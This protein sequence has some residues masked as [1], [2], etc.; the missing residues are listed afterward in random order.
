MILSQA[1]SAD[2]GKEARAGKKEFLDSLRQLFLTGEEIPTGRSAAEQLSPVAAAHRILTNAFGIIPFGVFQKVG[3]E[4]RPVEDETLKR[5]LSEAPNSLTTPYMLQKLVM[6]NAFWHGFGAVWNRRDQAGRLV[7]RISLPTDCCSIIKDPEAPLYWYQYNVDG[8]ERIFH[9]RELSLLFFETYNGIWG[10]GLLDLARET[11]ASDALAQRYG[12]KFYQ[13]GA[14]VSGIVE[15]DTDAK[16]ETK[17]KVRRE[18]ARY[19]GD[20]AFKVAVLDHGMKYTQLGLNQSDAQYMESRSFSVEEIARFTGVP[21][22]M[23]QTGN[24]SYNSN[25]QQRVNYVTDTLVPFVTQW[26]Q[27][28]RKKFLSRQ[29][30]ARGWYIHGNVSV[31]MRGDDL[32]RSQFY[33]RMTRNAIYN[34]DECRA[35]E[36]K[37]PIPGGLGQEFFLSKNMGSLRS[38]V[39]G[40]ENNG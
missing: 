5:L 31:L 34:P 15:V 29:Q 35:L 36:E 38:I 6:S 16:P 12:R 32:T 18:F 26:E 4:R 17:D 13:N 27:Q 37:A 21:K 24:E 7:E 28:D 23:L 19:A 2:S 3:G 30:R 14:R 8:V 10:R 40:G 1:V 33:E 9:P 22:H 11:V 39:G 20:D 25:Q